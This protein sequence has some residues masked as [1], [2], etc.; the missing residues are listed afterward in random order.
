MKTFIRVI[1]IWL[2]TR[3]RTQLELSG[4]LYGHLDGFREF[5]ADLRFGYDEGL[6]GRA[7]AARHPIILKDLEQPWFGRSEAAR[8]AGLTCGVAVPVFAGDYLLAVLC[9]FCGDSE[10]HV[11]AIELWHNDADEGPDLSL[12]EGYFGTADSFAWIARNT[13]FRC[14]FGIPG[15]VWHSN[16]PLIMEDLGSTPGFLRSEIARYNGIDHGLGIPFMDDPG[17]TY[18][19]TLLSAASSPIARRFEIWVPTA[20]RDALVFQ[21][22]RCD[23]TPD[24]A[25]DYDGV[26]LTRGEALPGQVWMSGLPVLSEDITASDTV[27][28]HSA[29]QAKL[30]QAVALPVNSNG[31]LRAVVAWYF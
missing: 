2:P 25:L 6:A 15:A 1:E 17:H 24:L 7:W 16:M 13:T 22:G 9:F 26:Q 20:Q 10:A 31:R 14:G 21:A 23:S 5:S 30:T 8:A 29:A 19:M 11:G 3:D 27:V 4:G 12:V 28:G 18:V